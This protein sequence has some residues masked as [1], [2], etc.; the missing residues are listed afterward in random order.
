M[1]RSVFYSNLKPNISKKTCYK[2]SWIYVCTSICHF[3]SFDSSGQPKY[4]RNFMK[5]RSTRKFV[6]C[7]PRMSNKNLNRIIDTMN[8]KKFALETSYSQN[9]FLFL[10]KIRQ[11]LRYEWVKCCFLPAINLFLWEN[12]ARKLFEFGLMWF[13]IIKK[14]KFEEENFIWCSRETNKIS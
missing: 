2:I 5:L 13:W 7:V 3:I 6:F 8:Y 11:F 12:T 4:M 9:I 10:N 1:R 14:I